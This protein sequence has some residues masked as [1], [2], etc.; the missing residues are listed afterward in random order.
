MKQAYYQ[1]APPHSIRVIELPPSPPDWKNWKLTSR[2][3][4]RCLLRELMGIDWG[5]GELDY[6][7]EG[8]R[9]FRELD[10]IDLYPDE[11]YETL[12]GLWILSTRTP[13]SPEAIARELRKL[14]DQE[15]ANGGPVYHY[16]EIPE[17]LAL[18]IVSWDDTA[19]REEGYEASRV[20]SEAAEI[21]LREDGI[22]LSYTPHAAGLPAPIS[23]PHSPS[24]SPSTPARPTGGSDRHSVRTDPTG[25]PPDGKEAEGGRTDNRQP[26]GDEPPEG[27]TLAKP[28]TKKRRHRP[29]EAALKV[30]AALEALIAKEQWGVEESKIISLARVSK[31]T[32]YHVINKDKAA[33][34]LRD[35]FEREGRGRGPAHVSE[36]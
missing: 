1:W 35:M 21:L 16:F 13:I 12:P 20:R 14:R 22:S 32:Y 23:P 25:G 26:K 10:R 8:N 2:A 9:P 34:R 19:E 15:D 30:R 31:S 28:A 24:P 3:V 33:R 17:V 29:G 5:L 11:V 36:I 6:V 18:K 27:S 7:P 4:C